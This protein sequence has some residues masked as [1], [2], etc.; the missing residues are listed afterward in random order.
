MPRVIEESKREE[1]KSRMLKLLSINGRMS[2]GNLGKN[3]GITKPSAY[4]LF[5][6]TIKEYDLHFVPEIDIEKIWRYEFI[7]MSRMRTKKEILDEAIEEIPEAGY[8]EYIVV[9]N[10]LKGAPTEEQFTKAVEGSY[11]P[12]FVAKLG[13]KYDFIMYGVSRN[14]EEINSFIINLSKKL[15]KPVVSKLNKIKG[16]F[17][18]F[19]L[20]KELLEKF[21]ISE[22]YL[23]LLLGLNENGRQEF[24]S[25]AKKYKKEQQ[26]MVYAMD[27]LRRTE[28]LKR[29]TYF[30]GK[31]KNTYNIVMQMKIFDYDKYTPKKNSWGLQI[32]KEY[33]NRHN[34]YMYMCDIS[35]PQGIFIFASFADK[36]AADKFIKN[37]KRNNAGIEITTSRVM[38]VLI[39]QLGVRDFDMKYSQQYRSLENDKL[40]PRFNRKNLENPIDE[41]TS[42]NRYMPDPNST[43]YQ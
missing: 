31:P 16:Q 12:Q 34:E 35:N 23:A 25:I 41:E 30:E 33:E 11:I 38:N 19:P 1:L 22:T 28:I 10:F 29:V 36:A 7:K 14:Y 37:V 20:R 13:G 18:F 5:L 42:E 43:E 21:N 8:E 26:G 2:I 32:M 17:G 39:G 40:V 24:I 27:R 6:E 15:K 4:H 9:F 3:L